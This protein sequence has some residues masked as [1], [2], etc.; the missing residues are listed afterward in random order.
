MLYVIGYSLIGKCMHILPYFI[1]Y[2]DNYRS[3]SN[4]SEEN[5]GDK[6][7]IRIVANEPKKN[8]YMIDVI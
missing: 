6:M 1:F 4:Y 7:T 8:V 2:F 3:T 5:T